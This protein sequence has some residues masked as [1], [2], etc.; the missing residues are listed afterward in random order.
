MVQPVKGENPERPDPLANQA[1][2]DLEERKVSLV[3]L[4]LRVWLD[5]RVNVDFLGE[6]D[7]LD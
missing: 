1:P 3:S 5:K 4:E 2:Q 6:L 7:Y